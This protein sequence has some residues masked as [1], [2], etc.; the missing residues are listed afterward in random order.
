MNLPYAPAATAIALVA[1]QT[2]MAAVVIAGTA[3]AEPA[4]SAV[5][6]DGV[7]ACGWTASWGNG[8]TFMTR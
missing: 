8:A 3:Y 6:T 2:A 4:P 1:A 5:A 7:W